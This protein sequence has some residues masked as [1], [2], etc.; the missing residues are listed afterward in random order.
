MKK[1]VIKMPTRAVKQ[2]DPAEAWVQNRGED[3]V[4]PP[5]APSEPMKRFTIDVSEGLHK[6]IKMQCAARGQKMA[7][8]IR[9]LLEREFPTGQGA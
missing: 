2:A 6:R 8:V 9:E 3:T 7:D 1:T 4:T 5:A